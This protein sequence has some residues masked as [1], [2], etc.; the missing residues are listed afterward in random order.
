[1]EKRPETL[2]LLEENSLALALVM[3]WMSHQK[4]QPIKAEINGTTSN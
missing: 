4:V 2:K 3:I 1:M